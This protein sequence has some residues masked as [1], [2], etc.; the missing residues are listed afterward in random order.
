MPSLGLMT[1]YE[2]TVTV[3]PNG[4]PA[5]D[6]QGGH[7]IPVPP[8]VSMRGRAV[9]ESNGMPLARVE[10]RATAANPNATCV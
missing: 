9:S 6:S 1:G 10:V 3:W 5:L 8:A 4:S 2:S 7:V